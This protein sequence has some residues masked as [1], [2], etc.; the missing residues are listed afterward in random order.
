MITI[1][2]VICFPGAGALGGDTLVSTGI[3]HA[4]FI[5][6]TAIAIPCQ[7]TIPDG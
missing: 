6:G 3:V 4:T 1:L 5:C 7:Y 2:T